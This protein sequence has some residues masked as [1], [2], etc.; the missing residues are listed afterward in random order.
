VAHEAIFRRWTALREWIA[1]EREFLA[2]R[3][4]LEATRRAWQATPD[5]SKDGALLMGLPL[6]QAQSWLGKRS[7]DLPAVDLNFIDQSIKRA[8]RTHGRSRRIRAL[9]YVLLVGTIA[10]LVG[11]INQSYLKEKWNW[12]TVV[13]PYMVAQVWP[14]VLSPQ[15]ERA[16][17]PGN[18]F[19]ECATDCPVVPAGEFTMG[20]SRGEGGR[21]DDEGPRHTV[22]IARPF[23]ASRFDV[24]FAD[25][26]A[27]VSLGGCPQ[28][29]RASDEGWGRRRRP[30]IYVNW[31]DARAYVAWL[32]KMTGKAY[33]LLTEAEW[34]YAARAGTTTAYYWGDEIGENNANCRGCGSQWDASRQTTSAGSFAP[35]AF[36]LYDMLGNVWQW[37][38]DCYHNNYD[39][40][41]TDASTWSASD[42]KSRVIR[43]G[44]WYDAPRELRS[45]RRIREAAARVDHLGFRVGRTLVVGAGALTVTPGALSVRGYP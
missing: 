12:Y 17:N 14:Y 3:T 26:D 33:R 28:E 23:A 27:C 15:V 35:N 4:G 32:S 5:G 18:S 30:V 20:S 1:A 2:W 42:C 45:A 44:S 38:E 22:K 40:A 7:E 25:W 43:G 41:P 39:G 37:V 31:E 9:V 24:T 11:W 13:R 10:G 19:R 16:L 29:G 21:Y 6:V 36:G 8:S 34:E